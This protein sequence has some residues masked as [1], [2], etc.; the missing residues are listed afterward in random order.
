MIPEKVKRKSLTKPEFR[1]AYDFRRIEKVQKDIKPWARFNIKRY[2]K[3][4]RLRGPLEI[5]E[6]VLVLA[7]RLKIVK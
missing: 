6:L 2:T 1:E 3:H 7:E 5:T 4:K